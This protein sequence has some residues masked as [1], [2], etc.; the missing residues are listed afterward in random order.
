MMEA[1][2]EMDCHFRKDCDH[3]KIHSFDVMCLDTTVKRGTNVF[4]PKCEFQN[5]KDKDRANLTSH[6]TG[7]TVPGSTEPCTQAAENKNIESA[8]S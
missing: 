8:A 4:C 2:K 1:C 7:L 5:H 3:S 6:N